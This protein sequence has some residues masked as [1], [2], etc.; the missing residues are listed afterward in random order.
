MY[1]L[2]GKTFLPP[3]SGSLR[4]LLLSIPFRLLPWSFFP[5]FFW[6]IPIKPVSHQIMTVVLW[7]IMTYKR[8][9][10]RWV[11]SRTSSFVQLSS[12]F[13]LPKL[14]STMR[15][16]QTGLINKPPYKLFFVR[17][18]IVSGSLQTNG[19]QLLSSVSSGLLYTRT[20]IDVVHVRQYQSQVLDR[21]M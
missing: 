4:R 6:G 2:F 12:S 16:V 1:L 11:E 3:F 8:T 15:F 10:W 19:L 17:I 5:T 21:G 14:S 13:L 7:L 9:V 20:V 18:N